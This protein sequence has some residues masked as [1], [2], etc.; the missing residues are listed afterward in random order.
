MG[1][2]K[3]DERFLRIHFNNE[4][5]VVDVNDVNDLWKKILNNKEKIIK[6][7]TTEWVWNLSNGEIS[8]SL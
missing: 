1:K 5:V 3:R 6:I 2:E 7:E 4:L 8:L